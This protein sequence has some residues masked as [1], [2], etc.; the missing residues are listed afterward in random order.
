M[1]FD[2]DCPRC[3]VDR[4]TCPGCG[5]QVD[6]GQVACRLCHVREHGDNLYGVLFEVE[7]EIHRQRKLKADGRFTY[8][9][10]DP[11]SNMLKNTVLGE[12]VGE[13]AREVLALE[14]IVQEVGDLGKLRKELLQVAALATSWAN[15][16]SA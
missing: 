1:R 3:Q 12:E 4:H 15:S 9:I 13:V 11:V 7:Q 6:H 8:T 16:I 5:I 14:G 10:D 2:P